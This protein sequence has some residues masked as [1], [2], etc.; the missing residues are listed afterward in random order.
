MMQ[1]I[2][3]ID[4]ALK[5]LPATP[6]NDED[7]IERADLMRR[8]LDLESAQRQAARHRLPA[9]GSLVVNVPDDTSVLYTRS[10]IMR[11]VEIIDGKRAIRMHAAELKELIGDRTKGAAWGAANAALLQSMEEVRQ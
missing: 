8:R 7:L 3:Q 5:R 4:D 1:S 11:Y 6:T 9:P 2:E 10:G